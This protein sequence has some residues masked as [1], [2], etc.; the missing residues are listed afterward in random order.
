MTN[1]M[2]E[3]P[4]KL[5]YQPVAGFIEQVAS[6]APA[7]GGGSA[8]ALSGAV[9]AGLLNMVCHFTVGKKGYEAVTE[10]MSRVREQVSELRVELTS[11]ID[12]DT[13]AFNRFRVA[14]RMA[15]DSDA[16]I[17]RKKAE[18]EAATRETIEAPRVTMQLCAKGLELAVTIITKGNKNTLSDAATGAEML[19]AGLD[20][21]ANNVLINLLDRDDEKATALRNEVRRARQI[22]QQTLALIRKEVLERLRG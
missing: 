4:A 19:M 13:A 17:S 16:A 20:G 18:V 11:Q 2:Q 12:E 15:E 10:E 6:K 1:M 5:I 22:A 8:A 14:N 7:P 9:G 3:M 21:A